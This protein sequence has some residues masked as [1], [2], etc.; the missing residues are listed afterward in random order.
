MV[1]P[2]LYNQEFYE[3]QSVGSRRSAEEILPYV[4]E[5]IPVKSA[6]DVGCGVGTWLRVLKD[7]GIDDI[8]GIDG[9]HVN[10]H[11]LQIP[12]EDFLASDLTIALNLDRQFDLVISLEVAEHLPQN[13]AEQ[14]VDSLIQLGPVIM[15]S[16]AI[17]FQGGTGHVNEQW[18]SY[19]AE[20]FMSRNYCPVDFIRRK[21]WDNENVEYW[22]SQ[23]LIFYISSNFLKKNN[24]ILSKYNEDSLYSLSIVHPKTYLKYASKPTFD[25]S[26]DA[27]LSQII[28]CFPS[29][30]A[31]SIKN[32]FFNSL[33]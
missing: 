5:I 30:V 11:M 12:K 17:P 8:L 26:R 10:S 2:N 9:H 15:F 33:T 25:F 20:L 31:R 22:Y 19:W 28:R 6:V 21:I 1:K 29:V 16:A 13:V 14:F 4:L 18:Q 7:H 32:K 23:N 27:Y 3:T 24:S